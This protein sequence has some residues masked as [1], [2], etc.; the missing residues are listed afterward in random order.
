MFRWKAEF[1]AD[2]EPADD[3][4]SRVGLDQTFESQAQAEQWLGEFWMDLDD[5]GAS[6]VSLLEADRVVYGPM[7]LES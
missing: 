3:E 5:L 6:A 7:P 1:P 2:A 4:L